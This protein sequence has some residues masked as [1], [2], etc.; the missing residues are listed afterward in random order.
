MDYCDVIY[1][2]LT[3]DDFYNNYY[4]E[5]ARTDPVNTNFH[6]TNEIEAVQ[7]NA[8]SAIAGSARDSSR[9]KL[10]CELGLTSLYD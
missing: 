10:Y 8:A 4:A 2:M 6:C 5:R 3:Y 1:H 9:D 7:Y